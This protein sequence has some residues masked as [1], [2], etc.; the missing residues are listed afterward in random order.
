MR[1]PMWAL[2]LSLAFPAAAAARVEITP[3]VG[4]RSG[5]IETATGIVCVQAPCASFAESEDDL[6]VGV[7]VDVPLGD[8]FQF[9][10]SAS[11]QPTTLAFTDSPGGPPNRIPRV[12]LDVTH[13]HAR[14]LKPAPRS[15]SALSSGSP[16]ASRSAVSGST[17]PVR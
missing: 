6:L 8:G 17:L 2:L 5:G 13:L 11:Y 10:I 15:A 9:E 12:D 16:C 4:Y 3:Q 1:N 14:V 7:A